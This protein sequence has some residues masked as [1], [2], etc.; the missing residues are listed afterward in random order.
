MEWY[1]SMKQISDFYY[2]K[3]ERFNGKKNILWIAV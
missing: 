2:I 3:M 1:M